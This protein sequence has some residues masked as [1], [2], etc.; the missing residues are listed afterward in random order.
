MT[1]K[2]PHKTNAFELAVLESDIST[3]ITIIGKEIQDRGWNSV[4]SELSQYLDRF[5]G[6]AW[7]ARNWYLL[8]VIDAVELVGIDYDVEEILK[9]IDD[10]HDFSQVQ[11]DAVKKLIEKVQEQLK[12]GY[13]TFFYNLELMEKKRTIILV[14][15]LIEARQREF[16]RATDIFK[17]GKYGVQEV[18][19]F[20]GLAYC[21]GEK[22]ND[23]RVW[24]VFDAY[25]LDED[26]V[27]K[28]MEQLATELPIEKLRESMHN[29]PESRFDGLPSTKLSGI[30]DAT[31]IVQIVDDYQGEDGWRGIPKELLPF[32]TSFD[33]EILLQESIIN[34]LEL[35]HPIVPKVLG[36]V[37]QVL[38]QRT[39]NLED[40]ETGISEV[41]ELMNDMQIEENIDALVDYIG[42]S[43]MDLINWIFP[44]GIEAASKAL[45]KKAHLL[46]EEHRDKIR[47]I[48]G[49][50][51]DDYQEAEHICQMNAVVLRTS[52]PDAIQFA[53]DTMLCWYTWDGHSVYMIDN[54]LADF[55]ESK[56]I[57]VIPI[58]VKELIQ[59]L[60]DQ[61]YH[62]LD[63][64][65]VAIDY[66]NRVVSAVQSEIRNQDL[67]E[68]LEIY[69]EDE[70][71]FKEISD[72]LGTF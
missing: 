62:F 66:D 25:E 60:R 63:M 23:Y 12:E 31:H 32:Y 22:E 27:D 13:P 49:W 55:L 3:L 7:F 52:G 30:A 10:Y 46:T 29:K 34:L 69:S 51:P 8:S 1:N 57:D 14:G 17:T 43:K 50:L 15:D 61:D 21:M 11:D 47:S 67:K 72:I 54:V 41:I 40:Y 16:I 24:E 9:T 68:E 53:K 36:N 6:S 48:Y 33:K 18:Y 65:R 39:D 19:S 2:I 70:K 28:I 37:L 38:L 58:L 5:I 56:N 4:F 26:K 71:T 20:Y 59:S 35:D 64:L 44:P 42:N 45:E